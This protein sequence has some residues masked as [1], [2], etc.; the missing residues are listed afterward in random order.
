MTGPRRAPETTRAWI[1]ATARDNPAPAAPL[2]PAVEWGDTRVLWEPKPCAMCGRPAYMTS[3]GG[4]VLHKVCHERNL[5][6]IH[7][8]VRAVTIA[9]GTVRSGKG[10]EGAR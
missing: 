3:P 6:A 7:G 5:V 4:E 2:L 1:A 10:R 9:A 8:P